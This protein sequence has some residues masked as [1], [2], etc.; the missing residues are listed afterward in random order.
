LHAGCRIELVPHVL[1]SYRRHAAGV[2][3][4]GAGMYSSALKTLGKWRGQACLSEEERQAVENTCQELQYHLDVGE[5]LGNIYEGKFP[6]ARKQLRQ[7][8]ERIPK[9]RFQAARRGLALAARLTRLAIL[10]GKG[11][12]GVFVRCCKLLGE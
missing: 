9:R 1:V 10:A 8:C 5:A 11:L 7:I 12:N 4:N 6:L 3:A 2:S